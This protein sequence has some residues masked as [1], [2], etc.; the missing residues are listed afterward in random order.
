MRLPRKL[1]KKL[2]KEKERLE[3][4]RQIEDLCTEY[5]LNHF[6]NFKPTQEQWNRAFKTT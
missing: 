6:K 5:W 1:K 2:K 4:I 3:T